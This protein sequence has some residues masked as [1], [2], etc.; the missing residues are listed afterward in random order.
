MGLKITSLRIDKRNSTNESF[1][2]PVPYLIVNATWKIT[3]DGDDESDYLFN[4]SKAEAE[5]YGKVL[6]IE[7]PEDYEEWLTNWDFNFETGYP[8]YKHCWAHREC[9][10]HYIEKFDTFHFRE[11]IADSA[12]TQALL[13]EIVYYKATG[14]MLSEYR[15]IPGQIILEHFQTLGR[16]WD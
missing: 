11:W 1:G 12:V 10:W 9:P 3:Q 4:V 6:T 16:Y 14:T 15:T 5:E 7:S 13:N 2:G 8:G